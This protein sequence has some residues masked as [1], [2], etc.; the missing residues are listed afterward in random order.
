MLSSAS[1]I[2]R[3]F[4]DTDT[5][6]EFRTFVEHAEL[7]LYTLFRSI[8]KDGNGKLDKRELQAAFK[9]AGITVANQRLNSFFG[10]MDNN[11]DGYIT[12]AEW[13]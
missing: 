6:P 3:V 8:D 5:T 9:N 1:N 13:R 12:F 11:N 7:Q 10:D 2:L 4:A